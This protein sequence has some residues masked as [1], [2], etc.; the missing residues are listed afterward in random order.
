MLHYVSLSRLVTECR[1]ICVGRWVYVSKQ[2][3]RGLLDILLYLNLQTFTFTPCYLL[4][5]VSDSSQMARLACQRPRL[6]WFAALFFFPQMWGQREAVLS[7]CV[8]KHCVLH[9]GMKWR[10]SPPCCSC[11]NKTSTKASYQRGSHSHRP[12]LR[13]YTVWL[14][15]PKSIL[16]LNHQRKE[17][18][19]GEPQAKSLWR[20]GGRR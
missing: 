2:Y 8:T 20:E 17:E 14:S 15:S 9:I 6:R 4:F 18:R 13:A 12:P 19:K 7:A 3:G 1:Y 5:T 16:R 10:W 11:Q